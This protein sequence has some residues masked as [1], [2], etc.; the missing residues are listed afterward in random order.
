MSILL[1]S[2]L[3]SVCWA[4][5]AVVAWIIW[6]VLMNFVGTMFCEVPRQVTVEKYNM[7]QRRQLW[8]LWVDVWVEID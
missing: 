5:F 7:V 3:S 2:G 8:Y 1:W 4:T 6:G